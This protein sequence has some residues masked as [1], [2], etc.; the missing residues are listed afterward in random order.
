MAL[1][2]RQQRIEERA[3]AW[4][5]NGFREPVDAPIIRRLSGILG[6]AASLED[7]KACLVEKYGNR[8]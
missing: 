8:A 6:K 4:Q 3:F 5:R 2:A 7:Y 1:P